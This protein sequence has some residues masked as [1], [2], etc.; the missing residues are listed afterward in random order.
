MAQAALEL[1]AT[2]QLHF[3]RPRLRSLLLSTGRYLDQHDLLS[4]YL[5]RNELLSTYLHRNELLSA[6]LHRNELLSAYL[7]RNELLLREKAQPKVQSSA[8]V[9]PPAP[10]RPD[11][12]V[13]KSP[14]T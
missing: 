6:Y 2:P 9:T 13:K 5:H 1:G 8:D 4:T 7:H 11:E 3:L 14:K 12:F 10:G